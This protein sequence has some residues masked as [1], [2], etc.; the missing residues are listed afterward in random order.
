MPSTTPSPLPAAAATPRPPPST[1]SQPSSPRRRRPSATPARALGARPTLRGS[2]SAPWSSP[3]GFP[4][5]ACRRRRASTILPSRTPSWRRLNG[6][7]RIRDATPRRS[8][9]T[10]R[11]N[12]TRENLFVNPLIPAWMTCGLF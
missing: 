6:R 4:S 2:S 5:T 7:K 1:P 8:T 3:S 9:C 12:S 11:Y 10:N